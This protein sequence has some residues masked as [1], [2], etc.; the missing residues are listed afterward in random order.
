ME[1][2]GLVTQ[3][4]G[5]IFSHKLHGTQTAWHKQGERTM[6]LVGLDPS[7]TRERKIC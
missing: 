3:M 6:R 1:G 2:E 7:C 5:D 4:E